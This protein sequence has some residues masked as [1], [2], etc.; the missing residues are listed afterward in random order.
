VLVVDDDADVRRLIGDALR[1]FGHDVRQAHD[2]PA[3]LALLDAE[4]VDVL[5][6]D[7]AMPGMDGAAV[8]RAAR[9]RHPRLPIVMISGYSDSDAI[10]AAIG[11]GALL[12]R[13]PFGIDTL[14]DVVEMVLARDDGTRPVA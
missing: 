9:Q 6:V 12:L 14:R 3:G 10:D 8:A 13:K 2:G 5:L 4:P 7:F 1:S 11:D